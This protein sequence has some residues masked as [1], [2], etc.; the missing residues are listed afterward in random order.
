VDVVK[1]VATAQEWVERK[2]ERKTE[3]EE[4]GE[5]GYKEVDNLRPC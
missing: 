2:A 4:E 3:R 5:G 1:H